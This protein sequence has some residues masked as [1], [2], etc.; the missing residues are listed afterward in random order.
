LGVDSACPYLL[1]DSREGK[2]TGTLEPRPSR[3]KDVKALTCDKR[4]LQRLSANFH[5]DF[6]IEKI[7]L[8]E[9]DIAE[10]E[11]G[12]N[13]HQRFR[14]PLGDRD[15]NIQVSRVMKTRHS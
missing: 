4:Q 11:I 5:D 1:L 13:P 6:F 15:K 10:T 3:S 7:G 12:E 14:V 2:Q 8:R 9:P